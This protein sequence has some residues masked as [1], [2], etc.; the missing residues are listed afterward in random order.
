M[1]VTLFLFLYSFILHV[2]STDVTIKNKFV[3]DIA[4]LEINVS[5]I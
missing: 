2:P 3:I 4:K 5:E 1:S